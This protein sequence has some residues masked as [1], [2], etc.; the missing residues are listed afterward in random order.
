MVMGWTPR[1]PLPPKNPRAGV[2]KPPKINRPKPGKP[3]IVPTAMKSSVTPR[4]GDR[5]Q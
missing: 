5:H 3:G 2:A 1:P 4:R